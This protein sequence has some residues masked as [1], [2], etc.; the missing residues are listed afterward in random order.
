MQHPSHTGKC[1]I[2]HAPLAP[3]LVV[4]C[5]WMSELRSSKG[6]ENVKITT[7]FISMYE[8]MFYDRHLTL[9]LVV[10]TDQKM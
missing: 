9:N 6:P 4:F 8:E 5:F 2:P 3:A 1:N 10:L 7:L